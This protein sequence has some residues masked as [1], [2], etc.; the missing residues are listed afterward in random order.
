MKYIAA[1]MLIKLGG[2]EE[3]TVDD[4]KNIIES[5]GIEFDQQKAKEIVEKLQGKDLNEVID[6]GKTKL[7]AVSNCQTIQQNQ[8]NNNGGN[9]GNGNDDHQQ[10][11]EETLELGGG[12]DDLFN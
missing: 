12:F 1:Y 10:E 5:V 8:E 3:V 2:K 4:L 9:N 7:N 6:N 11:E